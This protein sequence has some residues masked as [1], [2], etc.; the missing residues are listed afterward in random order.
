VQNTQKIS[1]VGLVTFIVFGSCIGPL[2]MAIA[3]AC[4][5]SD[6]VAYLSAFAATFV[7]A[8]T[9][10]RT[11]L[12]EA[13]AVAVAKLWWLTY[14]PVALVCWYGIVDG[15]T[16]SF[17]RFL[18]VGALAAGIFLGADGKAGKD[19]EADHLTMMLSF[20]AIGCQFALV[21]WP[22]GNDIPRLVV[23]A[24]LALCIS[25]LGA[26]QYGRPTRASRTAPSFA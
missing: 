14:F 18:T 16:E 5:V 24:S 26:F 6:D 15:T 8:W 1:F 10:S 19:A 22:L 17:I 12:D 3:T 21:Q 9:G 23:V 20:I 2:V 4:K 13:C 7:A 11:C 25:L